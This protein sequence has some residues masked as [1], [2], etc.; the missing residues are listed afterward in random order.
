VHRLLAQDERVHAALRGRYG[1]RVFEPGGGVD[2]AEL[3]RIVFADPE[4]LA[5]LEGLLHPRVAEEYA[6][7][8]D[9][10]SRRPDP[11]AIVVTEIPLLY[12]TGREAAFDRVVAITAPPE[13][14]AA[15][16]GVPADGRA[17]RLVPEEE[18]VRRADFAY[19]NDGSLEELDAFVAEV[20]E[21]LERH[22]ERCPAGG[23]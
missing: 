9:E 19:R 12:E 17:R 4:E 7:W 10:L 6:A 22:R 14:R 23:G 18:K 13:V 3:G 5:F 21:R 8:L 1:E 11:P 20:I 16:T 2:R 15:R